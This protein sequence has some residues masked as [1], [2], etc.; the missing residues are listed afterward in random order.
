MIETRE[1]ESLDSETLWA[2][3]AV[4]DNDDVDEVLL[5]HRKKVKD[6]YSSHNQHVADKL[7]LS[8]YDYCV[9]FYAPYIEIVFESLSE[10]AEF[11]KSILDEVKCN[12]NLITSISSFV[13]L[14]KNT[15]DATVNSSLTTNYP[16]EDA[17][18]DIGAD[19]SAFTGNGVK[20]GVLEAGYP[21][22]V[23]NF[24]EN[25]YTFLGDYQDSHCTAVTSIIGGETGIA[26]DVYFY[27]LA[28]GNSFI[29]DVNTLINTYNVDIIN[30]SYSPGPREIHYELQFLQISFAF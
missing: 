18:A 29:D 22:D 19:N 13:S 6:Y 10:Y 26:E 12:Q 11:E 24:K 25:S 5:Q 28:K 2:S 21:D 16:F 4:S 17:I 23:T 20:V 27:C 9:S 1:S 30:I 7:S 3:N 14:E 15:E 8:R